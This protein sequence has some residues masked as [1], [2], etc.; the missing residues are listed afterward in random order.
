MSS[1]TFKNAFEVL[2]KNLIPHDKL[3][4]AHRIADDLELLEDHAELCSNYFLYIIDELGL[5]P[6]LDKLISDLFGGKKL[7]ES[8]QIISYAIYY[9][10]LG[11]INP[12]FQY[13]KVNGKN[14][15]GN[16]THSFFSE[17]VLSAFIQ[18]KFAESDNLT[19]V[20]GNI[21]QN[22]H[23]RLGD[24]TI[25]DYL[26]DEEQ[27]EIIDYIL[28]M[29]QV[30]DQ[31]LSED[32][33]RDFF[34]N[35][36]DWP[37]LFLFIKLLY[38]LLVLSD[39]YSTMHYSNSFDAMY[40]LN[41]IDKNIREKMLISYSK[42]SYNLNIDQV[43]SKDISVCDNINELRKEILIE[44]N[45]N[46][47]TLLNNNEK[48]FMLAVP[49]GGGKTNISMKLALNILEYDERV[50]RLFYVFPFINIIEQNYDVIE[51]TL[52]DDTLFPQK[53]ALI[54]DIYSRAYVNKFQNQDEDLISSIEKQMVVKNDN[55]LNNCVN[56]ITGVNFFNAI[57]KNGSD[58]RYKIAYLCN[59]IVIID[60]IQTLSDDNIRIFY[61]FIKE[62]SRNLNIYYIIMSATL[63]DINDF[64]DGVDIPHIIKHPDKYFTHSVFKRNEIIFEKGIGD[65]NGIKELLINE[66][67]ENYQSG[68]VKILVTLNVVNTSRKVYNELRSDNKFDEFHIYLLNSTISSLRRKKII[69]EIKN[70]DNKERIIIVSTQSIEAG[71]DI[72]CDFGIRDY[73]ILD[74][75]EQIS[76]RINRECDAKKALVSK[77]FVIM[78]KD[79]EVSDSAKIYRNYERYKLLRR[80]LSQTD[81]EE[82]LMYKNFG[83]YYQALSNN[84][85]TISCDSFDSIHREIRNLHYK[86]INDE[87]HVIDNKLNQLDI[88][89][90]E[91]I[92]LENLSEYDKSKIESLIIDSDII[93]FEKGQPI[94]ANGEIVTENVY[95]VWR[96]ILKSTNKFE[97]QY[98]RRKITSLFNQ[99]IISITNLSN[100]SSNQ[101]LF[102]Y[103]MSEELVEFDEKFEVILSTPK[104]SEYYSFTDG[105]RLDQLKDVLN[106]SP[107]GVII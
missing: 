66:I 18:R 46:M 86:T 106:Q 107:L 39:S 43:D 81:V 27:R 38:S 8:K 84:V 99:F 11:K 68:K 19:Y 12:K 1:D 80:E 41:S 60:E 36:F 16:T 34:R 73:S 37:K 67:S 47:K 22:H 57:I 23:G 7:G 96:D 74:S 32:T 72:D 33:K 79:G 55:F 52:F 3:Y 4:S 93:K 85:K 31:I 53:V 9:H 24:F 5:E 59:S 49:T 101:D 98:T 15:S 29:V 51:K 88:F 45:R 82:I 100:T 77:L 28:N 90:C 17:W 50:K 64:I 92:P 14:D 13:V 69:E 10:D 6:L 61:D 2:D 103:L 91:N 87:L 78:Y 54:S 63:P 102:E 58:N 42:I 97:D 62:T 44:C 76:G 35:G 26:E 95:K 105:L 25:K 65:I 30:D 48:I 21:I 56:V 20:I 71:V 94:I 40:P 75:I 89:V 70:K 83:K 104:L